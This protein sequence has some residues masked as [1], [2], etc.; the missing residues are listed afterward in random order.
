MLDVSGAF[1]NVSYERLLYNMRKRRLPTEIVDWAESYLKDR[2]T[3]I[4]LADLLEIGRE[5]EL[6]TGYIDDTGF[7]VEGSSTRDTRRFRERDLELDLKGGRII[8]A[9]DNARYLGV[10]LD[11]EL[12]GLAHIE[13][14][15]KRVEVSIQ[16]LRA[17]TGS[18]WGATRED[19]L[20]LVKAI[21]ML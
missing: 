19:M 21:I 7:L 11:K 3:R 10:I 13:H 15:K 6:I 9:T 14:V 20:T 8:P 5:G 12:N 18:K 16:A 2:T 17:I 4:K 1:D